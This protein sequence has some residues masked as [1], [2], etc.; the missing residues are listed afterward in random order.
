M[1]DRQLGTLLRHLGRTTACGDAASLTDGQLL[2]RFITERQEAAFESLVRRH[3]RMVFNVCRRLLRRP[4]DAEDA[5][6][7]TFLLLIRRAG[8]IR[9][10]EA[11]GSWLYKVAYRVALRARL[12]ESRR[13]RREPQGLEFPA[14]E[15]DD[16]LL[17]RDL[18]P[19]LDEEVSRLPEKYRRAVVLCYLSGKSTEEAAAQLGCPRGT[20]LSR[21]AWARERLHRRL[22]RPGPDRGG[23]GRG[24]VRGGRLR[25]AIRQPR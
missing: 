18:R 14:D 7:A 17:C 4:Q 24:A 12:A 19:V 23:P 10:R 15:Q 8:S 3:G 21:L 25:G 22:A 16:S 1:P 13:A 6:Q 2:E 5:F 20:V 11:V 9:K